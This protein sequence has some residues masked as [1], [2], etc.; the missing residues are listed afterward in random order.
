MVARVVWDHAERFDS[1]TP[2]HFEEKTMKCIFCGNDFTLEQRGSGGS[3]RIFCY[4]CL[5]II[6]DRKERNKTRSK[7]LLQLANKIKLERGC[8]KCGYNK[9][10]AALEWHH[11]DNNKDGDPSVLLR[12][13]FDKY[14]AE[15]NKCSLLCANCH[16]EEHT[17]MG[18]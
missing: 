15:I 7:L 2:D 5:P 3:N 9:C 6:T 10:A 13:S 17:T 11:P 14:I 16:R 4:D 12:Y 18:G 1:Y 8:D